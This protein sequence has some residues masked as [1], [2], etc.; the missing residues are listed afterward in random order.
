MPDVTNLYTEAGLPV[1]MPSGAVFKVLTQDEADYLTDR[2]ARYL[3]A[4]HFVATSNIA[5]LQDIDR[6]LIFEL[7]CFRL[8][9]FLGRGRDYE[10]QPIE[11]Q[12]LRKS[13]TDMSG[14]L[15]MLKARLQID[16]TSRDRARGAD[17]VAAYLENLRRRAKEFGVHRETQLAKAL[18][19]MNDLVAFRTTMTNA[20]DEE[21]RELHVTEKDFWEWLD[22]RLIP[23]F[24]AI[25]EYFRTH[26]QKFWVRDL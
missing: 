13:L 20:D 23:Q 26:A 9:L 21:K 16:K 10:D 11:A 1:T 4:N 6:M 5:D 7:L 2:A 17:S 19:L 8:G 12:T 18:E 24:Q 25:D 3:D 15:R 22:G 14:E